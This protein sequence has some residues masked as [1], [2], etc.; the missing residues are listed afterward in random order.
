MA[1]R[2]PG[3]QNKDKPFRQALRM[4]LAAAGE[5]LKRLRAIARA[6]LDKAE[7]GDTAAIKE[8]ADRLDGRPAQAVVGDAE[9]D[10]VHIIFTG[11]PRA[12]DAEWPPQA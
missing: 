7:T 2:P 1:G 12:G 10:P 11:V 5:D 3:A 4:E 9:S 8:L 6:L